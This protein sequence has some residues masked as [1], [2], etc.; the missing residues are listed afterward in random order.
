M[1]RFLSI[2]GWLIIG[3]LDKTKISLSSARNLPRFLRCPARRL[4]AVSRSRFIYNNIRVL[5]VF[6]GGGGG[7][8]VVQVVEKLR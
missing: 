3:P 1:S 6:W 7:L 5:F 8:A 2:R 4:V